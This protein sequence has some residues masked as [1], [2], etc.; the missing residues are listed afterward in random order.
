MA[1]QSIRVQMSPE[2][3][4][5]LE[6][7]AE[8]YGCIY[9]KKP[10]ISGLLTQIADGRLALSRS[11]P[12]QRSLSF[13]HLSLLRLQI[14]LPSGIRGSFAFIA[15][16]IA[17]F[18]GNIFKFQ[19]ESEKHPVLVQIVLCIPEDAD[20]KSLIK[21]LQEIK[22]QDV[23]KFNQADEI[24]AALEQTKNHNRNIYKNPDKDDQKLQLEERLVD[25]IMNQKLL[26]DIACTIGLRLMAH[27]QVGILA[28]VMYDIAK[29]GFFISSV[30]QD[31]DFEGKDVIELLITLHPTSQS[32]MP[33]EIEKINTIAKILKKIP[34]IKD[35]QHLGIDYL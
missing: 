20:L 10:Y 21:T 35:V 33:T 9:G 31:F 11:A 26:L 12:S 13:S 18:N 7:L 24:L 30:K 4:H 34:G 27:N 19:V 17:D 3:K 32:E 8:K 28:Q 25:E 23:M 6:N 14:W 29:Q 2:T 15:S 22:I 5:F 1:N 16:K